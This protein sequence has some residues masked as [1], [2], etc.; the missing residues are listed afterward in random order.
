M[1]VKLYENK[2]ITISLDKDQDTIQMK[3]YASTEMALEDDFKDWN[4]T[5]VKLVDE[6]QPSRM[7]ADTQTYFFT[8]NEE[9]Q[10]WSK[11][12]IFE[13]FARAGVRKL[14]LVMS[15]EIIAQMSLEQFV[16]KYEGREITN[17]YFKTLEEAKNWL[18]ETAPAKLINH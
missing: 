9:L 16:D 15:E 8:I 6:H 1:L 2:F 18:T 4:R 7:L 10:E 14:A 3:W 12:N 13:A 11:V 17:A 5:L